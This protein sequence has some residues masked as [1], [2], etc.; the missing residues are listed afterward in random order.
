MFPLLPKMMIWESILTSMA[1]LRDAAHLHYTC[2]WET[3]MHLGVLMHHIQTPGI[4]LSFYITPVYTGAEDLQ[5]PF[6]LAFSEVQ[7]YLQK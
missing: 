5:N 7:S 4:N 1:N 3:C 6:I 2:I